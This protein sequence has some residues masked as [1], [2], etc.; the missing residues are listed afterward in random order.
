MD[1][2]IYEGTVRKPAVR[3]GGP[4]PPLQAEDFKLFRKRV[5]I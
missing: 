4:A 2:N 3:A 5:W 1:V